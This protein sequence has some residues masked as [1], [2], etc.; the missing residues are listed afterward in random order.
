MDNALAITC[1]KETILTIQDIVVEDGNIIAKK[2]LENKYSI[3][4]RHLEYERLVHAIP[5]SMENK[6]Y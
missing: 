5:K 1:G 4:C 2:E 3:T 6:T